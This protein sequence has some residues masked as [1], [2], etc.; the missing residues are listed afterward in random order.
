MEQFVDRVALNYFRIV[1]S[2][3]HNGC[4][5]KLGLIRT[6]ENRIHREREMKTRIVSNQEM[7]INTIFLSCTF[8]LFSSSNRIFDCSS[9]SSASSTNFFFRRSMASRARSSFPPARLP[10][11]VFSSAASTTLIICRASL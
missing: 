6:Q 3:E 10:T 9:V 5:I 8:N 4:Q 11:A 1:E 7:Q 2:G